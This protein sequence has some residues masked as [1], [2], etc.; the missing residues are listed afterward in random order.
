MA[1]GRLYNKALGFVRLIGGIVCMGAWLEAKPAAPLL[2][3]KL[4]YGAWQV[5]AVAGLVFIATQV[6]IAMP[7]GHAR[8]P[9]RERSMD[10][11]LRLLHWGLALLPCCQFFQLRI[12]VS[13]MEVPQVQRP[14]PCSA[15]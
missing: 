10:S 8:P 4:G 3:L 11:A 7:A 14:L 6:V 13:M 9:W 5:W 12:S 2:A 1:N 15:M